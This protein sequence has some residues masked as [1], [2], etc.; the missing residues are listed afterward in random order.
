LRA[1]AGLRGS[2][3]GSSGESDD[4]YEKRLV[5]LH[6]SAFRSDRQRIASVSRIRMA[7]QIRSIFP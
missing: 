2:A 1:E 4:Q 5:Q 6:E 3:P 7:N